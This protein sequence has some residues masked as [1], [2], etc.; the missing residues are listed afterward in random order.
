MGIASLVLG[1]LSII[2]GLCVAI[3]GVPLGIVGLALGI[4]E[5]EP[6]GIKKAGIILNII[7][8]VVSAGWLIFALATGFTI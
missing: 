5:K 3:I 2:V 8:L 4:F 6:S 7:G 1:I